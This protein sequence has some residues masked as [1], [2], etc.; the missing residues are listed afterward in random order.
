MMVYIS[1]RVLDEFIQEDV[2]YFDFT[3]NILGVG[4]QRGTLSFITR[5]DTCICGTEEV[6][7]I[8]EKFG[9]EVL[10]YKKSGT[11]LSKDSV[12]LSAK[13][14]AAALH[15]AWKVSV[16]ILENASGIAT[17]TKKF[18]DRAKSANPHIEVITT[19]KNFPGTKKLAIKGI[20][21]GGASPH[22]LG[23]SETVLV[24]QE[25]LRFIGGIDG[26]IKNITSIKQKAGEKKIIAEAHNVGDAIALAHAGVDVVQLDKFSLEHLH[27]AIIEIKNISKDIKISAAGG[28]NF[29]NVFDIASSGVD[30]ITTSA[31]YFGKPSDIKADIRMQEE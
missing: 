23:L 2:P 12:C 13:G 7:R 9:I 16:N 25:H 17:R 30:F 4:E 5:E 27:V 3:S 28:V 31:L 6:V 26:F 22:R 20:L 18:V 10:E 11:F 1:D 8:L 21:C 15:M 19:R 29:D 14:N 24:F